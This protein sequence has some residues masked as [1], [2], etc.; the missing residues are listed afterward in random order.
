MGVSVRFI[1]RTLAWMRKVMGSNPGEGNR[2]F[3]CVEGL[4]VKDR[5]KGSNERIKCNLR[6]AKES[7]ESTFFEWR[8]LLKNIAIYINVMIKMKYRL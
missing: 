3:F 2:L 4:N 6:G 8:H 1:N 5:M 7:F